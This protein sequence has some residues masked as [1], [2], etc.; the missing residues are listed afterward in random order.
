MQQFIREL[1]AVITRQ[2]KFVRVLPLH[3]SAV[4]T[5]SVDEAIDYIE[6][7]SEDENPHPFMK[8]EIEVVYNN[9]NEI[10]GQF[11]D[12]QSTVEFLRNFAPPKLRST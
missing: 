8:Y 3:G 2:V 5:T 10:I 1:E 11:Q 9:G 6:D 4:E 7:Y 12:K